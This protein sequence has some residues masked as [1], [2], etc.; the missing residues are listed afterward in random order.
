MTPTPDTPRCTP[1]ADS[2]LLVE[3]GTEIGDS[4]CHLGRRVGYGD[5][6]GGVST[7]R[8]GPIPIEPALTYALGYP[9]H[10]RVSKSRPPSVS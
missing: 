2:G 8:I 1:V 10:N 7:D 4:A 9:S 3:F 5:A 6:G